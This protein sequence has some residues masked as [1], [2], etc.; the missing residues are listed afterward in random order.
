MRILPAAIMCLFAWAASMPVALAQQG[1]DRGVVVA[2]AKN[3]AP[4][5]APR[6]TSHATIIDRVNQNTVTVVSG[7]PN[8]TLLYLAY[9]L[10]AVLDDDDN[11]RVLP[12]VGKGAFQNVRDVLYLARRRHRLHPVEHSGP[13]QAHER[14]RSGR[15]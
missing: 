9:D 14:V 1:G 10:S 6:R 5:A 15:R 13:Y 3:A 11:L 12:M 4:V 2:Q 8:G 7:N